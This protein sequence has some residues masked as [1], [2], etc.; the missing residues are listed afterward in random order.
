MHHAIQRGGSQSYAQIIARS[1]CDPAMRGFRLQTRNA[2]LFPGKR[3][4][5]AF[6]GFVADRSIDRSIDEFAENNSVDPSQIL[7]TATSV[8]SDGC[9]TIPLVAAG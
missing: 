5:R 4:P 8:V 2:R 9:L 3:I 6:T 1:V 7:R